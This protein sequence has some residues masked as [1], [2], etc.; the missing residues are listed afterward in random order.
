MVWLALAA[1]VLQ[2]L[3]AASAT[4]GESSL[5]P[6]I[7]VSEEYNDNVYIMPENPASDYITRV[8]PFVRFVHEAPVWEWDLYYALDYRYYAYGA[9]ENDSTQALT[10]VN[11]NSIVRDFLFLDVRDDYRRVSLDTIQDYTLQSIFVNQ[12][13][14]NDFRISPYIKMDLTSHTTGTAGYQF[15]S[16]WYK[17][18]DA[19]DKMEHFAFVDVQNDLSLR[20]VLLAG[21]SY[22]RSEPRNFNDYN[23]ADVYAGPRYEYADGS[24]LWLLIGT[25]WLRSDFFGRTSQLRWDAGISHRFVS[26]TISFNT[27][28]TYI[29]D[30]Q[31]VQRREDRYVATFRKDTERFGLGMTVG[32]WEYRNVFTKHLQDTRHGIG[33]TISYRLTPS[34]LG[35]YDLNIDRYEDNTIDAFSMVYLNHVRLEYVFPANTRLSLAYQFAHG[36]SPDALWFY[37]NYD[38]N[39]IT[40]EVSKTF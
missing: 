15:R 18:G 39:R 32:R 11:H 31:R 26:Y 22:I 12:T 17:E 29:D 23:R 34:L 27:A 40:L 1:G 3:T 5:E 38:N 10:L 13:D 2:L 36:Y 6:G 19:I 4:A 14:S 35:R 9:R 28:L 21:T 7:T 25:S 24:S 8:M 16:L 37:R 33:G 20:T 30:P